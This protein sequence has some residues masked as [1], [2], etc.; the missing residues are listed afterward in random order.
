[1]LPA[2]GRRRAVLEARRPVHRA[3]ASRRFMALRPATARPL[4][5]RAPAAA[6][7][8]PASSSSAVRTQHPLLGRRAGLCNES[9]PAKAEVTRILACFEDA[10]ENCHSGTFEPT[11]GD[12]GVLWL[13]LG[14]KGYYSLQA[15]PNGQL[16]LF[17]PITGV[18]AAPPA[19]F[20]ERGPGRLR[21]VSAGGAIRA[22]PMYYEYDPGN[23]WW[24]SPTDGHLMDELLVR[25]LMHITSVYLNL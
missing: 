4:S 18:L 23:K 10:K 21:G 25:E 12:D 7:A 24:S 13:N 5:L 19:W 9:S 15:Q 8:W 2:I 20:L 14:D 6:H 17:S 11:L 3:M 1:M 22:G 16:L